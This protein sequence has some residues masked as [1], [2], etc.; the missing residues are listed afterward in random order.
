MVQEFQPTL[1]VVGVANIPSHTSVLDIYTASTVREAIATIRL[2]YFDL[3]VVGLDDPA[4]DVWDLMHRVLT[5]RPQ[6]RWILAAQQITTDEEVRVRSLGALMVLNEIPNESWL[7]SYVAA[8]RQNDL[9]RN[10]VAP[11]YVDVP[12]AGKAVGTPIE[13]F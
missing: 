8:L 5:A 1:L 10:L 12:S 9:S 3:L 11:L 4:L 6:Q 2:I 7:V 13:A